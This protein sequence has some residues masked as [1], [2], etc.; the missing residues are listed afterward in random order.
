MCLRGKRSG[1]LGK[2]ISKA[3]AWGWEM[4]KGG[5]SCWVVAA[6]LWVQEPTV[7][8]QKGRSRRAGL[9]AQPR[10]GNG[11]GIC[12][13]F[14]SRSDQEQIPSR[15][16]TSEVGE[17]WSGSALGIWAGSCFE[18][19]STLESQKGTAQSSMSALGRQLRLLLIAQQHT[20]GH[21]QCK[22]L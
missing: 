3:Q 14:E 10:K 2:A 22:S 16:V 18:G 1:C 4:E 6:G 19:S 21:Q 17:M 8:F 15:P 13:S 11:R 7:L 9:R 20:R 12:A 5:G